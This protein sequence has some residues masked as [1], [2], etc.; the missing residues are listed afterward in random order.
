MFKTLSAK[1]AVVL[2]TLLCLLG[3]FYISLTLFSTQRYLQEVSQQFN[4]TLAQGL[5]SDKIMIDGGQV[6]KVEMERLFHMLM[7]INPSIEIYLL[8][9]TG[10]ILACSI[11]T[12]LMK[13]ESVSLDPIKKF[14]SGNVKMPIFG[15]DPQDG[16]QKKIFSVAPIPIKTGTQQI[17][18]DGSQR[19]SDGIEPPLNSEGAVGGYLYVVLGGQAYDSAADMLEG[20]YILRLSTGMVAAS[21]LFTLFAGLFLFKYLTRRL[22]RLTEVMEGFKYDDASGS[23]AILGTEFSKFQN[24]DEIDRLGMTFSKMAERITLQVR[25]LRQTD[26]MRRELVANVSHDLRTPLASLQ[27]YIETLLL[28]EGAL[29]EE[30]Q[31]HYLET[32]LR[33][34]ERLN[35]LVAELF[36]L[37]KLDAQIAPMALEEFALGELAQDVVQ[38]FQL[39]AQKK[40][41]TLHAEIEEDL[42]F[43]CADIGLIERVFDNLIENALRHT[44]VGGAV[45]VTVA[46]RDKIIEVCISDNGCGIS[47]QDIAYIFD[48]FY[49]AEKARQGHGEG[50]GLG[51][52]IAKRILELHGSSI[53]V[54]SVLHSGTTFSFHLLLWKSAFN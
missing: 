21:V 19:D 25:N 22:T 24:S 44:P 1:L 16:Q 42:L 53:E 18:S 51:L 45:T 47:E 38:E 14:L 52:T 4:R 29:T 9:H 15:D 48:R 35:K 10:K 12:E 31:R 40:G 20:S 30:E 33:H 7:E 17:L 41:V 3:G 36:E 43:V 6:N 11:P 26:A 54:R 8:D 28:K 34:S 13:L 50:A 46:R 5:V 49:R 23:N 2:L 32:A 39:A 37:A 27:G